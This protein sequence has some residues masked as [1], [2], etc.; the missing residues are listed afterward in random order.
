MSQIYPLG[1]YMDKLQRK[2]AKVRDTLLYVS[3]QYN[4]VKV[5][6]VSEAYRL[7]VSK[8]ISTQNLKDF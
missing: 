6:I 4:N 2:I 7:V 5:V 8:V 3:Q 1:F